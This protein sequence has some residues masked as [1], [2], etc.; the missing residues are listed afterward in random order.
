VF[1]F[2]KNRGTSKSETRLT[3]PRRDREMKETKKTFAL[4]VVVGM[5]IT[6]VIVDLIIHALTPIG[7]LA[8]TYRLI[9]NICTVIIFALIYWWKR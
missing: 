7:S 3:Y 9:A 8:F 6:I 2:V 5:M 1:R 4:T